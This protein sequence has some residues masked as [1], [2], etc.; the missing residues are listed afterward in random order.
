MKTPE[1]KHRRDL[2]ICAIAS[3]VA[4]AS[5]GLILR[6]QLAGH[7][8]DGVETLHLRRMHSHLGYYGVLFPL[9]WYSLTRFLAWIPSQRTFELYAG[10]CAISALGFLFWDYNFISIFGSSVVLATWVW[11]AVKN[12]RSK[13]SSV[14][15][16]TPSIGLAAALIF[17]VAILARNFPDV[18][19]QLARTFLAVLLF[20][21]IIPIALRRVSDMPPKLWPW[22]LASVASGALLSGLS[23][24]FLLRIGPLWLAINIVLV[25]RPA[26]GKTTD[27]RIR[28]LWWL[29]ALTL[30]LTG[31]GVLPHSYNFAIAG[32]HFLIL[33]PVLMT[34]TFDIL[35][36]GERPLP[37]MC[38]ELSLA[39]MTISILLQDLIPEWGV[40]IKRF[41]AVASTSL[42]IFAFYLIVTCLLSRARVPIAW[43]FRKEAQ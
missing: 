9:T 39:A 15:I 34:L 14:R 37:R 22:F 21:A 17:S 19:T 26:A 23:E 24:F 28:F 33:G 42:L 5:A 30:G 27:K 11:F 20:G 8:I 16:G 41:A 18:S 3:F 2:L 1:P 7:S 40:H 10:A 12:R 31:L 25:V 38:Y 43:Y 32:V 6:W 13:D 36:L 35:K 29:F 4:T